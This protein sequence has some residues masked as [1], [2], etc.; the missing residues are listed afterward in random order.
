MKTVLPKVSDIQRKWYT[1]DATDKV[2]GKIAVQ[3][4]SILTGKDKV[5]YTPHLDM[6]DCL[7][8]TN[9]E[10]VVFTGNKLD[11]KKYYRYS[12]H[13]GNVK[14]ASARKVLSEKP[15]LVLEKAISGMLRKTKHRKN[16][17]KRLKLYIGTDHQHQAQ[18]PT[19]V[20]IS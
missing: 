10:K 3:A 12:G 5:D 6:G 18:S 9:V 7:V 17:L 11:Q 16:I 13:P 2:V 1:I 20:E 19:P 8:I 4:A 14:E 15:A